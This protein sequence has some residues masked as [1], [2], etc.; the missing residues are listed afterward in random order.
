MT[1]ATSR[2]A[3]QTVLTHMLTHAHTQDSRYIFVSG[4]LWSNMGFQFR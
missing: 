2:P 3:K 4:A 1:S